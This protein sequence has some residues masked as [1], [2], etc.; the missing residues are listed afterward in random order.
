M[1]VASIGIDL[2]K[3][4]F[5]LVATLLLSGGGPYIYANYVARATAKPPG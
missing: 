5:R 2:G 3:T 4:T 1:H